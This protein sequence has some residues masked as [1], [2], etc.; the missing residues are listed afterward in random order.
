MTVIPRNGFSPFLPFYRKSLYCIQPPMKKLS[1]TLFLFLF[2]NLSIAQ[3]SWSEYGWATNGGYD[4]SKYK[5]EVYEG[6]PGFSGY[7]SNLWKSK[8]SI[9]LLIRREAEKDSIACA[10]IYSFDYGKRYC[11]PHPLSSE[12]LFAQSIQDFPIFWSS[13][14]EAILFHVIQAA[15]WGDE[16][17]SEY[18]DKLILEADFEVANFYEHEPAGHY[19]ENWGAFLYKLQGRKPAY[20]AFAE[21]KGYFCGK[22]CMVMLKYTI[23]KKGLVQDIEVVHDVM[24]NESGQLL[25]TNTADK[26]TLEYCVELLSQTTYNPMYED[27]KECYVLYQFIK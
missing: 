21:E 17:Q 13:Y 8:Y 27:T 1:Q 3:T 18:G 5:V 23:T 2:V 26:C 6:L 9:Q 19:S 14:N 22:E 15:V 4:H 12:S 10:M 16:I 20:N 25:G 24:F 7:Y 11:I